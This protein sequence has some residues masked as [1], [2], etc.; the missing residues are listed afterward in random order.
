MRDGV[1][2]QIWRGAIRPAGLAESKRVRR[3]FQAFVPA[4]CIL[5][6]GPVGST[7]ARMLH[8]EIELMP[9]LS[10]GDVLTEELGIDVP[11]GCVVMI[12]DEDCLAGP[13]DMA[14][15][16]YDLGVA[17]ANTAL[18][19][20]R[21]GTFPLERENEALF[22][23]ACAFD[24]MARSAG[25][26]HLGLEADAFCRGLAATLGAYWAGARQPETDRSGLFVE[27]RALAGAGLRRYL[28]TMEPGFAAPTYDRLPAGLLCFQG[29]NHAMT[30][31]VEMVRGAVNAV[32]GQRRPV[33][34]WEMLR[35]PRGI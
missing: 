22:V 12:L 32:L 9:E 15:L 27:A 28:A 13:M 19:I 10:L 29:A 8:D 33:M 20:L 3:L 21:I 35:Q 26:L 1:L 31:W 5:L 4:R 16:S 14:L 34:D 25:L 23:M 30:D 17:V 18:G 24:R 2:E 7:R 11:Y 6:K